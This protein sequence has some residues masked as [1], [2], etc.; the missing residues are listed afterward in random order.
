MK[1]FPLW[2]TRNLALWRRTPKG[3]P[4][5]LSDY[6][7]LIFFSVLLGMAAGLTAVGLHEFIHLMNNFFLPA[8]F[9]A[10]SSRHLPY[11]IIIIPAL[12]MLIQ[13]SMAYRFPQQA[14][15]K[16]VVDVIK[17]VSF[18]NGFIPL[19]STV[20]HFLAPAV[21]MGTGGTVGPEAPAAQSGAGVVSALGQLFR[22]KGDKLRIFTAA[23]A[24]AAIAGVFN[25]PLAGVFFGIEV[26]L[27]NDLHAS[28]LT[29]FILSSVS[30]SA[31]SRA[32]LGNQPKFIFGDLILGSY[33]TF[34][35]YLLLGLGAGLLSIAFIQ[36]SEFFQK[37]FRR[38]YQKK[39]SPLLVM[40]IIG[41][42]MGAA[43]WWKPEILGIGYTSINKV[44]AQNF[45]GQTV[46]ILFLLKFFLVIFILR[47][48]GFGGIFAPSMFLG[49]CYGFI[50]SQG[51]NLLFHLNLDPTTYTLVGMGA[52]LAGINSVPITAILILF[53][54]TNNYYFI[55]PLM[56]GTVGSHV[57]THM[58]LRGSIYL[59][60]LKREGYTFAFGRDL[61]ILRSIRVK[62]VARP[63]ILLLPESAP[64]SEV[65]KKF[66]DSQHDTIYVINPEH[67]I[68]GV[69]KSNTLRYL[70]AE[71]EQ[72]HHLLL[73]SDIADPDVVFLRSDDTLEDA[74]KVF[75]HHR[76]EEI[77][78]LDSEKPRQI[79]GTLHYQ[80]VLNAYNQLLNRLNLAEGLASEFKTLQEDALQ[81]V[82]PGF[83]LA[84]VDVPEEFAGKSIGEL[85]LRNKYRIDVLMI[86]EGAQSVFAGRG[87]KKKQV[88]PDKDYVLHRDD[89]LIIYGRTLDVINFK[90]IAEQG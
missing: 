37:T 54:M 10:S 32:F 73:A 28:A 19:K 26:V 59:R 12:G 1:K 8:D 42:L 79:I 40:V 41:L 52:M 21:C 68:T 33:S 30:A 67:Q 66:L 84:E 77:P 34:V 3:P 18:R 9:E 62:E 11:W 50:F 60:E 25:T 24:G 22:L 83:S 89:R 70:L 61:H 2:S 51:L 44:L 72:L 43:G 36:T 27:L 58:A 7:S 15:Q 63:D 29:A 31:V 74:M 14:K 13:W 5:Q 56:L 47:S 4:H 49:A 86:E 76:V 78:V 82:I 71:Y 87:E 65:I 39:I 35:F 45:T 81:E 69:I 6:T 75:A 16:G 55:L 80:D 88:M 38:I 64:S 23:G 85:Q 57:V 20:F 46:L 17:S 90:K 53:E 48:G